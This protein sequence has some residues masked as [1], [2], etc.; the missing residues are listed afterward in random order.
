M[1]IVGAIFSD[2]P[3]LKEDTTTEDTNIHIG[4]FLAE[5]PARCKVSRAPVDKAA[6]MFLFTQRHAAQRGKV[7]AENLGS[8]A[9]AIKVA[10]TRGC[11]Q[12]NLRS[13]ISTAR[14]NHTS[15]LILT[16]EKEKARLA[17]TREARLVALR[18]HAHMYSSL[19]S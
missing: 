1:Q 13:A 17:K 2:T 11:E 10:G 7:P 19:D 18:P 8:L 3:V 4:H 6:C 14:T 16:K 12:Y 9:R 5:W 15:L